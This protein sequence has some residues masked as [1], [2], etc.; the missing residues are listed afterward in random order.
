[1]AKNKG[2]TSNNAEV[3]ELYQKLVATNTKSELKGKTLPYTPINGNMFSAFTRMELWEYVYQMK[4][5]KRL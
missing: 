3:F 1:M 4:S 5:G 2:E